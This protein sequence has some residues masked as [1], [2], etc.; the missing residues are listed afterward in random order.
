MP[1]EQS[2]PYITQTPGTTPLKAHH[3]VYYSKHERHESES[4]VPS[5]QALVCDWFAGY[6]SHPARAEEI[7]PLADNLYLCPSNICEAVLERL[8]YIPLVQ[9]QR[10][11]WCVCV[12]VPSRASMGLGRLLVTARICAWGACSASKSLLLQRRSHENY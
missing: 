4:A 2:H 8:S 1:R 6:F 9:L 10:T 3:E 11:R 5:L 7:V 12:C